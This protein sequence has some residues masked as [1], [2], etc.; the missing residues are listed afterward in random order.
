LSK[1]SVN[2]ART[3]AKGDRKT[4]QKNPVLGRQKN[5]EKGAAEKPGGKTF[6]LYLKVILLFHF[7]FFLSL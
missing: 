5:P 2:Y 6:F 3:R 1:Y 7:F 4:Q